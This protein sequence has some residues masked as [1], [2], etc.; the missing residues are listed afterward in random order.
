MTDCRHFSED[1]VQGG[2]EIPCVL[3]FEGDAK[4]TVKTKKLVE[5]ALGTTTTD[6]VASKERKLS[7]VPTDLLATS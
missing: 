6:L 5:T 1:L 3:I 7:D 4:Y 2:L